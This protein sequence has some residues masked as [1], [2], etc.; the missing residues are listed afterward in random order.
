MEVMKKLGIQQSFDEMF[1]DYQGIYDVGM[2]RETGGKVIHR[3]R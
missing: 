3:G 2:T 1:E